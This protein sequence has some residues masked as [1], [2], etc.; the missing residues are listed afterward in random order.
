MV[1]KTFASQVATWR[2]DKSARD[3]SASGHVRVELLVS[4]NP[5]QAGKKPAERFQL[6]LD[7]PGLTLAEY[8]ALGYTA[9]DA[10][11]D[12]THQYIRFSSG[13]IK[14]SKAA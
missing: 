5:K 11:W 1:K 2:D 3:Y 10:S 13:R 6:L 4:E 14:K 9:D 8:Y 7:N 12:K